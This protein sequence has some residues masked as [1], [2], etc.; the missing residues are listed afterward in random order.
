MWLSERGSAFHTPPNTRQSYN[1]R[2][3]RVCVRRPEAR[4]EANQIKKVNWRARPFTP[5]LHFLASPH[6]TCY[7]PK[8]RLRTLRL[9][10]SIT[11]SLKNRLTSNN[12]LEIN[13]DLRV[14]LTFFP[15]AGNFGD[16]FSSCARP[17]LSPLILADVQ[18]TRKYISVGERK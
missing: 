13:I 9:L 15:R 18:V 1:C 7:G 2:L 6:I 17:K 14:C 4:A 8:L 3:L 12:L 16:F 11:P 5:E 10:F